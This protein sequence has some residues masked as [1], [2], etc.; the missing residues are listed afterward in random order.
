MVEAWEWLERSGA[1]HDVVSWARVYGADW[2]RAWVECPRGDWL[3]GIAVRAGGEPREVV[4]AACACARFAFEYLPEAEARPLAAVAA[5]EAWL[6]GRDD[7]AARSRLAVEVEALVDGAPDPAV[8]AA[9]MA[10]LAALRSIQTPEDAPHAAASAVQAALL[11]AGDCAMMAAMRH[12]Q[13]VC[14]DLVR[15]HLDRPTLSAD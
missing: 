8:A 7:E 2:D 12:A 5:A 6:E 3:L 15:Q 13:A 10:A 11:D 14:A 1:H 4:E 9:A